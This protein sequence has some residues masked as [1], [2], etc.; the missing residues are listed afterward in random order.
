[1]SLTNQLKHKDSPVRQFFSKYEDKEGVKECLELLQSTKESQLPDFSPSFVTYNFI[2]VVSDYL[3]RYTANGNSL[4]FEETIA[5]KALENFDSSTK[6]EHKKIH[7]VLKALFKIGM[8]HLDG[9]EATEHS[10]IYSATALAVI[11]GFYRS[12][13]F[14]KI[15]SEPICLEEIEA[16]KKQVGKSRR[17]KEVAFLYGKFFL[18]L[19]GDLY[20]ND[21]SKILGKFIAET[22]NPSGD[23]F[24][25]KFPIFN[26]E[27]CN[28]FLVGGAD[29]DCIF[30]IN[31]VFI[32]TDIKTTI[33]PLSISGL[34][35]ILGYAL[36]FNPKIDPF[37]FSCAGIYYSR[38]GSF[39]FLPVEFLIKKILPK[40][41]NAK[42]ARKTFSKELSA[43]NF[44]Y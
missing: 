40:L 33:A 14:P 11:D 1:M 17:E 20:A 37:K 6:S 21:I 9:R 26:Q 5:F 4:I 16:V 24:C 31:N 28:S 27:F 23:L 7:T 32:L 8:C 3:I 44:R 13:K 29:F 38:S 22:S 15:F 39:K 41:K 12:S 19:G 42:S 36:I 10:T 35:Q 18:S 30:E 43:G 34:R 2:G 25:A